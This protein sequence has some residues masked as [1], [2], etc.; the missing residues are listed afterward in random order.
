MVRVGGA[1]GTRTICP[2]GELHGGRQQAMTSLSRRLQCLEAG[3]RQNDGFAADRCRFI[4]KAAFQ[5]LSTDQ[6]RCL[7]EVLKAVPQGRP[8]TS[9]EVAAANALNTATEEEC[10]KAGITIAEF[11][12]HCRQA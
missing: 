6:L 2:N 7:I 10:Q 11:K 1:A 12:R 4:R 8:M 5:H 9:E 3:C